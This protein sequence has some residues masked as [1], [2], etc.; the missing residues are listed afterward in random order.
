M[1]FSAPA[2][3]GAFT[4]K[5]Q[6]YVTLLGDCNTASAGLVI[7]PLCRKDRMTRNYVIECGAEIVVAKTR[8]T[9]PTEEIVP[10]V[11]TFNLSQEPVAPEAVEI[12]LKYQN[13]TVKTTIN[14]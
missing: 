13:Q 10:K 9:C 6:L 2:N 4:Y 5:N 1:A 14:K 3:F 12:E 11:F 7:T 8:M